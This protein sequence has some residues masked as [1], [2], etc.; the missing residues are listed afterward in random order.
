MENFNE[1]FRERTKRFA[2]DLCKS[3]DDLKGKESIWV[4]R[5]QLIRSG[6][7]VAANF[8]A[9]CRARSDAE[10]YSKICIVVEECDETVFWLELMQ[11]LLIN[12]KEPFVPLHNEAIELLNVFSSTKK[13]LKE[14]LNKNK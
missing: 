1:Q 3:F 12:K 8:R 6:T 13:K 7:S 14:K 9:A 4:I 5:K 10:Y 11:D 2:I